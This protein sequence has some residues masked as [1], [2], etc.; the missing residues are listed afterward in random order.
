M[1]VLEAD[2]TWTGERFEQAVQV[3]IE[4]GRI[5]EV[6]T[7]G[8]PDLR[9]ENRALLPGMISSHSHAFQRGLR[10]RGERFPAGSGSFW[11]WREAMYGLVDRLGPDEFQALCLRTFREMRSAGITCVGEFHYFHHGPELDG[12][13]FDERVLR[14][15]AEA[16]IRIALLQVYYRTGAIGQPL[17]G[18]QRRFGGSSPAA[19]WEQVDRL[20][21]LLDPATQTLGASVHSL[22]AASL[23]DLRGVYDEARRRDLVFHIHVEEQRR[24]IQDALA[25][26]GRRP[27]QLLLETLGTATDVTAVHCTHTD[28][29]DMERF[30]AGGGTVCLCPLTEGNLGD[31]IA[32]NPGRIS[33][34]CIGSDSNAR[35]S[36]LEEMRWLEYAQR[37]A[38]ESRGVLRDHDGQVARVLFEAATVNGAQALGVEAGR[39]APGYWADFVSID[40]GAPSLAGWEPDTLLD[41]LV[42]GA[43]D[44]AI[45]ATCVGGQWS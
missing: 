38:T 41:S 13:A 18:P 30:L 14:A 42:F 28:A 35:I 5:A 36:M 16:G 43:G 19:F 3:R 27:M 17:E 29:E 2:W 37:L 40:L 34:A 32:G 8:S 26:Y 20:G 1:S 11:T 22:R 33:R 10:G 21:A 39:I 25:Y 9:L 24:E 23:E 44:E 7:F 12:W 31:G 4:E 6:G 45:A 15:A